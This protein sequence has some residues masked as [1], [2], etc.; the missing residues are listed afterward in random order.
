METFNFFKNLRLTEDGHTSI[1]KRILHPRGTH[2]YKDT[3]LRL[4]LE[5]I[6][7]Q[8]NSEQEWHLT[9]KKSGERGILDLI[10]F[11]KDKSTIVVIEN[12]IKNADDQPSQLYRYWRNE[13]YE[14]MIKLDIYSKDFL[15]SK[16]INEKKEITDHYKIIYLTRNGSKKPNEITLKR[17]KSNDGKYEGFPDTLNYYITK[18]SY[19]KEIT[20]WL[21]ECKKEVKE[22]ESK[23]LYLILD[24]YIEWIESFK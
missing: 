21:E 6:G 12:K 10:I 15:V 3:F 17:P 20:K 1:L 8:Y 18:I 7:V 14:P 13:I 2:G 11:N 23:R 19:K 24:Q 5:N 22:E 4:F 16:E 9:S